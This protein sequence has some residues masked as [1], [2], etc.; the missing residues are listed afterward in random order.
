[1]AEPAWFLCR[2][3]RDDGL[4][5]LGGIRSCNR[6]EDQLQADLHVAGQ[7]GLAGDLTEI[8]PGRIDEVVRV[9]AEDRV[10]ERVQELAPNL[11]PGRLGEIN[12]FDQRE[13]P[14]VDLLSAHPVNTRGEGANVVR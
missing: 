2:F 3:S 14:Q 1:M 7:I 5:T 8:R 4:R 10:I 9:K 6:L 12:V 13:V 11:E